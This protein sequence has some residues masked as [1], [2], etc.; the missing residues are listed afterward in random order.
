M[1]SIN[2]KEGLKNKYVAFLDILGFSDLVYG[3]K[4]STLETYFELVLSLSEKYKT[5]YKSI[6]ILVISDSIILIAPDN[7]D[8]FINLLICIQDLQCKLLL[9]G[10]ILRGG[11]LLR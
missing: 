1:N 2:L 7:E 9:N 10:I 4:N 3:S 5:E 8:D 11:G 6:E